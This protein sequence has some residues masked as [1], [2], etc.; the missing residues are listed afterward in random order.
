MAKKGGL[1]LLALLMFVCFTPICSFAITWPLT[2]LFGSNETLFRIE[3]GL[4]YF[5]A[6][7][8]GIG[9]AARLWPRKPKPFPVD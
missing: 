8:T 2:F 6:A 3:L 5:F 1:I 7:A 4:V 9:I